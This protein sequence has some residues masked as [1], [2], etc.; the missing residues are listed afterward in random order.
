MRSDHEQIDVSDTSTQ[1]DLHLLTE[2][3]GN[4]E[5]TQRELAQRLGIALGLTNLLLRNLAQ[6]GYIRATKAGW[7]RW[8]YNLTPEG[9]IHKVQLTVF[10]ISR[11]LDNYK[12]V[13]DTLKEQLAPLALN[14][15]SRI[16]IYGT[17][18][19]AQ[20]VYLGLRELE[21]EEIDIFDSES[22]NGRK[23]LGLPIKDVSELQP[24]SYDRVLIGSLNNSETPRAQLEELGFPSFKVVTFFAD[25]QHLED[26]E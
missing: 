26:G 4:P 15:E 20:L 6:K 5:V 2:V 24:E 17:G 21:I 7:K 10:Y 1:R 19:F 3:E 9:F 16:A 25:G 8:I 13:R 22:S 18:E 23:F 14:E 11:V 12:K